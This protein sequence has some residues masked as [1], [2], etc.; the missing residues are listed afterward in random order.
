MSFI[1]GYQQNFM[2]R[3]ES[4]ESFVTNIFNGTR[5]GDWICLSAICHMWNIPIVTPYKPS[6]VKMFHDKP[7][8][9]IILIANGCL[10]YILDHCT[11]RPSIYG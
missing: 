10:S 7:K 9:V 1:R 5:W 2:I 6:I 4:Y 8:C 11:R 3:K